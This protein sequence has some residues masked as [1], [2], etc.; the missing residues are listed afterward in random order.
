M[1]RTGLRFLEAELYRIRGELILLKDSGAICE[2][3]SAFVRQ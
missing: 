1:K 3:E 2:A